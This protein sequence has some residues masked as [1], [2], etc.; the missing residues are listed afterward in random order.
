M[1]AIKNILGVARYERKMLLRTTK[2]RI[3]GGIGVAI[4][5]LQGIGLAIAEANGIDFGSVIGLG[6][7][8]PFYVYSYLQ[9]VVIAFIVG[10][11]RAADERAEIYEVVAARPISTAELVAGKYLGVVGA[12][13][14]LSLGVLV[15][16]L[17]IQAAKISITKTPFT[18]K[19]YLIYLLLMN[20]PGL[21]F[22]SAMTFFLGALLRRQT[23]VTLVTIAYG[24]AVLFFLGRR[25]GGIY[26]FGAFFAPLFYSDLIGLGDVE[27]VIDQRLFYLALALCF[28]GLSIDRYPRLPQ[29]TGWT[30][31]GR[32]S[33]IFGLAAA[34]GLYF[35]MEAQDT[36]RVAYRAAVFEEQARYA[37]VP[38]PE[39]LHY[40]LQVDLMAD[41][42]P[43]QG[44]AKLQVK[45]G[46]ET[47][48]DTLI[49]SLNPGL[50][51]RSVQS[52]AGKD[53]SWKREAAVI[54]VIPGEPLAP[55]GE[56][57]LTFIYG[58]DIDRD[59]FDLLRERSQRR[60]RKRR[61]GPF[62]TKGDLSMW[63]RPNSVFLP[64]RCLWYPAPSVDY[65]HTQDRPVS[66][67]TADI[68]VST[69]AGLKVIT[70]GKPTGR[71]QQGSRE[72]ATWKVERPVPIFSLNAGVYEV[73]E[74]RI[75]GV[76]CL[77]YL[78]PAHR[79]QVAFFEDAKEEALQALDQVLDTMEQETGLAYPYPRLSVVEVPFHVQW[80]YEGW[81]E[82]GGLT[83]PG[84]LMVE[85]DVLMGL[86]LS[87]RLKWMS[88]RQ[89]RNDD[90][91][92]LKR[93]LLVSAIFQTFF[94]RE[95][96]RD[97]VF[98]SPVA[99][100]WSFDKAFRGENYSLLKRGLPL[101]MQEDLSADLQQAFYSSRRGRGRGGFS[102]RR[103]P[104]RTA[105]TSWDTLV[106]QMQQ[107]S[108][109]D[110]NPVEE[111]DLYRAVLDAKGPPL[112]RMIEAV[113]GDEEFRNV[114]EGFEKEHQYGE[115][116]FASFEKAA[117][118]DTSKSSGRTNL[119]RLLHDWLYD[120]HVPGYTLTRVKAYKVDDDF[121]MVVYQVIVRIRNGEPGRGF[122]Q[123]SV[124]G[125]EDEAVKGV[126]IEGGQEVEVGMILWDRPFRVSVEPF[127]ARNRRPL[128]APLRIPE[129]PMEGNAK[130]YV[131]EVT[132]EETPFS[133]IIVDNDDDGFSM[134]IRR[135][136]RFLRPELKGDNWKEDQMRFAFGRYETTYRWKRAGDGAQPAVWTAR[137]PHAGDYDVAFYTIP[138]RF[139]KRRRGA[140]AFTLMV[141][142]GS[143]T[144]TLKL[145][146]EQIE[147][148]WHTLGRFRFEEG[149]EARVE[150]SDL[151]NGRIYADAV[152][153]RY[154]DPE[155]PDEVYEEDLPAWNWGRGGR[156][157]SR[158]GGGR[159]GGR[160]GGFRKF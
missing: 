16:A 116:T 138:P 41:G 120:T 32:G 154:V 10:D 136:Q 73:F 115:A 55:G 89:R 144:D 68:S 159:G 69:P 46:Q 48:L 126:E 96:S 59:G 125:R 58:G 118:S 130:S 78:H 146:S 74:A 29:S 139:W 36:G 135:V 7:Y 103:R 124:M 97:G 112:F 70:Q 143:E 92:Q 20:V 94:S 19:P 83:Q 25:Y 24:L 102:R 56:R 37:Q 95:T 17:A 79:K 147:G 90:P 87:Q 82:N 44:R 22:M 121:G 156:G 11:F 13:L 6:A 28:F 4:P 47:A 104:Q 57:R 26:D 27:R 43:L 105:G 49:F 31:F 110:V 151:A 142:H 85:E 50:V 77:L 12:L 148:G 42:I 86:R 128:V 66:F 51:L 5:V 54:R 150:L 108:F 88:R 117:M 9:A 160:G 107:R 133:E 100:L 75:H 158:G 35:Y 38:S 113:V 140:S 63:I 8:V 61:W 129:R 76:D 106:T 122:V 15:L 64:P 109:S 65:G 23:A 127:F 99:Q 72:R 53:V 81:Q 153:W 152:R 62:D 98:R 123:I 101:Y 111:A 30:W 93:D 141:S 1:N 132:E 91:A 39:V 134:P 52:E 33:A 131:R 45:N 3:L 60:L 40:D 137:L 157:R 18:V 155:N 80:Y 119:A 84:V 71:E 21:I 14:T 67:A 145:E 2:F 34:S 114:L 149:E